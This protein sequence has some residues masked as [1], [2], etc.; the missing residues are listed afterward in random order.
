MSKKPSSLWHLLQ[1]PPEME[2]LRRCSSMIS[3][4]RRV[5]LKEQSNLCS[6]LALREKENGWVFFFFPSFYDMIHW[7]D[8]MDLFHTVPLDTFSPWRQRHSRVNSLTKAAFPQQMMGDN[9]ESYSRKLQHLDVMQMP[10]DAAEIL[11][12]ELP[13]YMEL[14]II[15]FS[16]FWINHTCFFNHSVCM[17]WT[18]KWYAL[19]RNW[20]FKIHIG[21]YF[22]IC[23][24]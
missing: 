17:K 10:P 24:K 11:M 5:N 7:D 6:N 8:C 21:P 4:Q 14:Y 9:L 18:F 19:N 16:R 1:P 20:V 13:S 23:D 22:L 2:W 3:S 15:S 12:T